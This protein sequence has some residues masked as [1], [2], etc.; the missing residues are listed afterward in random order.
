[1]TQKYKNGAYVWKWYFDYDTAELF[2][3][4]LKVHQWNHTDGMQWHITDEYILID[5]I[6][7]TKYYIL[8]S[9]KE[10]L[11]H[12]IPSATIS[13]DKTEALLKHLTEFLRIW[14]SS[15]GYY[16]SSSSLEKL[17]E[18]AKPLLYKLSNRYPEKMLKNSG[19][20][21]LNNNHH[22]FWF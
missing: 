4:K 5:T 8:K 12:S 14:E 6:E 2:C 15:S 21:I 18:R 19:H 13:D 22:C 11:M 3:K 9:N 17:V 1:M 10:R 16:D 20:Q 7:I